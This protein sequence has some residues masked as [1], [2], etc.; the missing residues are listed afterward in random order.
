MPHVWGCC[1][2]VLAGLCVCGPAVS[3]NG[4]GAA[5]RRASDG[6]GLA[7]VGD[8]GRRLP[9]CRPLELG[10]HCRHTAGPGH[11]EGPIGWEGRAAWL[12]PLGRP[13][14]GS[15]VRAWAEK[16][17]AVLSQRFLA[18]TRTLSSLC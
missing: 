16:R 1:P 14:G 3:V 2:R 17:G 4:P 5:E 6:S 13:A 8:A 12:R 18:A 11:S 10:G 15:Q 7:M 9:H